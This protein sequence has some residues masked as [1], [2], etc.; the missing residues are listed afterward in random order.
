MQDRGI[1]PSVIENTIS[2]G[3][4]F[5]SSGGVSKYFDQENK[6]LVY[7][8]EHNQIITVYPGSK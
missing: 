1:M 5:K 6:V 2:V 3:K 8:G 4:C 7:V